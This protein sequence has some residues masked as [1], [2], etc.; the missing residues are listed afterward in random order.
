[1]RLYQINKGQLS[2]IKEGNFK[3]ERDLQKLVENNIE[4]LMGLKLVKSE[5]PIKGRRFDT[6]AYSPKTKS[7]VIIEYKR[8]KNNNMFDQGR[9]YLN[10]L[11]ENQA[12]AV[13]ELN[14]CFRKHLSVRNI[15]WEQSKI[16]F[17]SSAFT[18]FQLGSLEYDD[19][20]IE[21][22]EVK[23]Y[24]KDI[25]S[26]KSIRKVRNSINDLMQTSSKIKKSNKKT[27]KYTEDDRLS[28]A[29]EEIKKIYFQFRNA[30]LKLDSKIEI[31]PT[32]V[33]VGFKKD[34]TNISDIEIL[35]KSLKIYANAKWGK[36]EDPKKLFN[37]VSNIGHLGNGDYRTNVSSN[38]DLEYIM[39]VIK[40]LL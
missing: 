40:Q 34:G 17:I 11:K 32:G 8:D 37:N 9:T 36:L 23:K 12:A 6:L 1:M 19:P 25:M 16:I 3:V 21:V 4:T 2:E 7:F 33:Y 28:K 10:L 29:S 30:I 22:L 24:G 13:L 31:Q 39:S 20:T 35:S 14:N 26:F 15:D 38:K 18:S 5:F 27:K